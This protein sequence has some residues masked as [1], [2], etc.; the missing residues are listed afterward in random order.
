MKFMQF[1]KEQER[2]Q[3]VAAADTEVLSPSGSSA[4]TDS[5]LYE[6][7][8]EYMIENETLR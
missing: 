2:S 3:K 4:L 8:Q 6:M 1:L 7:L 5:G